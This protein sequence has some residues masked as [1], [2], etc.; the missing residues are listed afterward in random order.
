MAAVSPS[1]R[2]LLY[3]TTL[4]TGA[5]SYYTLKGSGNS[6]AYIRGMK[7]TNWTAVDATATLYH[8]PSGVGSV[9]NNYIYAGTILVPAK[10]FYEFAYEEQE[11]SL[12]NG[13]TIWAL[14]SAASSINLF[15]Y[16]AEQL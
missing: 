11:F 14:A 10:S 7:L 3:G 13:D 12:A 5:V 8:L 6:I 15:L 9:A 4:T 16:G 2:V 1:V